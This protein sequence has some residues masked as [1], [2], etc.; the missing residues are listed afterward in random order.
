MR[1]HILTLTHYTGKQNNK[2]KEKREK[3]HLWRFVV[4]CS[5]VKS[6]IGKRIVEK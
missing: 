3:D 5:I 6:A 4:C 2:E 1:Q